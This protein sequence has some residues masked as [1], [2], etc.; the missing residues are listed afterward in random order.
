[1]DFHPLQEWIHGNKEIKISIF[2]LWNWSRRMLMLQPTKGAP[3]LSIQRSSSLGGVGG[4]SHWQIKQCWMQSAMSVHAC[5][6]TNRKREGC[7]Q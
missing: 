7:T 6:A 2:V 3:P 5:L 4:L 1:M